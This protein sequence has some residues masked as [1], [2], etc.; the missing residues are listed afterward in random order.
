MQ[1][2]HSNIVIARFQ[3]MNKTTGGGQDGATGAVVGMGRLWRWAGW[4][5]LGGWDGAIRV[6]VWMGRVRCGPCWEDLEPLLTCSLKVFDSGAVSGE[7]TYGSG[8]VRVTS[9]R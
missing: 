8:D 5:D 9:G 6:R 1:N 4:G 2:Q 7:G 3:H